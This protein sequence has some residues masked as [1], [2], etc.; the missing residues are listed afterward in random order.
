MRKTVLDS[1]IGSI[2]MVYLVSPTFTIQHEQ[3]AN[4][5]YM[6]PFG[7][8]LDLHLPFFYIYPYLTKLHLT[9]LNLD[10]FDIL[11]YPL[12]ISLR[13]RHLSWKAL[14]L[15]FNFDLFG[16]NSG[17]WNTTDA[18]NSLDTFVFAGNFKNQT[19]FK[20]G[21]DKNS[22]A[23]WSSNIFLFYMTGLT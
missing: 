1:W 20:R 15:E 11:G 6:D 17:C 9:K 4:T 5:P 10:S 12:S 23:N 3:K 13:Q 14:A 18:W 19:W 21:S 2:C 7:V 22:E 16:G 8:R